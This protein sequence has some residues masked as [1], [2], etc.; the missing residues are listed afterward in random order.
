VVNFRATMVPLTENWLKYS[1]VLLKVRF[2][3]R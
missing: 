3:I 1:V 2:G